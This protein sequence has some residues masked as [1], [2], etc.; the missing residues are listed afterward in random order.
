[1]QVLAIRRHLTAQSNTKQSNL[2]EASKQSSGSDEL[3]GEN[4]GGGGGGVEAEEEQGEGEG[5]LWAKV[6]RATSLGGEGGEG[7]RGG[8]RRASGGR[9]GISKQQQQQ[10][11][12]L[13]LLPLGA[14]D[15]L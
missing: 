3:I 8:K 1:M 2:A 10:Q 12:Q 14:P 15:L 13:L 4:G 7:A 5:Y 11:Q 9:G 6:M